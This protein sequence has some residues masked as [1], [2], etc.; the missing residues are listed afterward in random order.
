M[1]RP[2]IYDRIHRETEEREKHSLLRGTPAHS[3][4]PCVDLATNSYLSLEACEEVASEALQLAGSMLSGNLASRL[5]SSAGPCYEELE[6]ELAE[7]K[8]TESAL[9]YNSGY[10]ANVG[11][12]PALAGRDSAIFCD[13]LNHASIIDGIRLSGAK[14][15]RYGHCDVDEL[16]DAVAGSCAREKIIVTD[17]VFSMDGDVAPLSEIC[18]IAEEHGCMVMVD[19][20]H[21]AGVFGENLSGIVELAGVADAVDV[22]VGTLSKAVAGLGGF[23]AGSRML[24]THLVNNSRSLIYST[25]LPH[26]VL[27]H[28]LAAVRYIRAN[29]LLGKRLLDKAFRFRGRLVELGFDTLESCS[30]IVP[31]VVGEERA[32]LE[33]SQ[34]LLKNGVHAPAIRPPTVPRGTAR[35][36]F[37]VHLGMTA[38]QEDLVLDV[39][40]KWRES[41]GRAVGCAV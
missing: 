39:L 25:G 13:R 7:W 15:V 22:R 20:A 8:R 41:R 10:A 3:T 34:L 14:L 16:R 38:A 4:E 23:F 5:I 29:P 40:R 37:S 30:Q 21:A 27:C 28:D 35:I 6:R 9:V 18:S 24:R 19:E 12:I 11:I 2:P 31:C 17:T 33:L 26:S 1:K 32:A 36:R